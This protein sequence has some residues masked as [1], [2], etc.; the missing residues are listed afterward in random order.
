VA[1][2]ARRVA[3]ERN[4]LVGREERLDQLDRALVLG[5]IPQRTVTARVEDRVEI[6][7]RDA[8]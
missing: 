4:R 7:L 5:E 6:S 1:K 3:D 2:N 8:V